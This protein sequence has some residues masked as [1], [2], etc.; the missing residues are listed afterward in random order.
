MDVSKAE[1]SHVWP[2]EDVAD[3]DLVRIRIPDDDEI[4][5]IFSRLRDAGRTT[6]RV[7]P[8]IPFIIPIAAAAATVIL[9]GNPLFLIF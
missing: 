5:G 7:T 3:G 1:R 9:I 2:L 4:E 6:V 8:R